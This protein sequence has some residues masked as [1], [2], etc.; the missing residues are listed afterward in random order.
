MRVKS[1]QEPNDAIRLTPMRR[2]ALYLVGIG[3]WMTGGM[4]LIAHY[5]LIRQGQFG[6]EHNGLEFSSLAAHGAFAFAALF[7]F[8]L[9]WGVHIIAG[10]KS[11]RKRWS[12]SL[13]FGVIAWL[14]VSGYLLYYLRNDEMLSTVALLHWAV[15]LAC[16]V[17][18]IVHC[19]AREH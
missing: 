11:L 2:M 18:F 19:F 9:M 8:G 13:L 3:L 17:P 4:W 14:I 12:G 1:G 5:F 7:L 6:P 15:G 10:W 16:P